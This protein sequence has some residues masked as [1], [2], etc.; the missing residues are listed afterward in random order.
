[1]IKRE[2]KNGNLFIFS[3]D[4]QGN[5]NNLEENLLKE[6]K[7]YKNW[8]IITPICV[9][10]QNR[11][12]SAGGMTA[13]KTGNPIFYGFGEE[14]FGQYPGTRTVEITQFFCALINKKLLEKLPIKDIDV[15]D[16][17]STADY[18]L[19]AKEKGFEILCTDKEVVTY[20]RSV[21]TQEELG[22]LEMK[23]A[24]E[25]G[26]YYKKWKN[27]LHARYMLP[28]C[29]NSRL[30]STSGF[31]QAL[32]GYMRALNRKKIE[33]Q[34]MYLLDDG[35]VEGVVMD[36]ELGSIQDQ[37]AEL[38]VPQIVWG[39]APYFNKNSGKYKIGHAE[40]EG[41]EWPETWVHWCNQMDELWVPTK[42]DRE[43]ARKAGVNVPIY[44]VYQGIDPDYFHPEV[45]PM[46]FNIPK[47]FKFICNAAWLERKNLGNLLKTFCNEF[48]PYEDVALLLHTHNPGL[49]GSVKEEIGKLKIPPE[50]GTAIYFEDNWP[51]EKMASFYTGGNCF[52]LPTHGEG[53][54][55]PIFEA[56]ACG[57]PTIT[58]AFGAPNEVLRQDDSKKSPIPGLHF[59]DYHLVNCHDKYEYL[60]NAQWAEPNLVQLA[61]K[62]RYVYENYK[63]EKQ[64]A[65]EGSKIVR[66]KFAWSKCVEPIIERLT[67][68]YKKGF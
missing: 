47:K 52:V 56:L 50:S 10:Q 46:T 68:I 39:Q 32:G 43:K 23:F 59:L 55:L 11:I 13:P 34:Y 15:R 5:L 2:L 18:C 67:E 35:C 42:W 16:M 45:A 44:I 29:Y 54:G 28:V 1:M 33:V 3:E 6:T 53:W 31:A 36:S 25:S 12:L 40:F 58:T 38:A 60:S 9:T 66:Q 41:A 4:V 26:E 63:E 64:K 49:V 61:E 30:N 21:P 27:K 22:E 20:K 17:F 37:P 57:V 19:E 51:I 62:M 65:I 24:K 8:G 48:G 7:E 14:Y